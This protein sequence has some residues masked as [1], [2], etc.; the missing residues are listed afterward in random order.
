MRGGTIEL[1]RR[2]PM[3]AVRPTRSARAIGPQV[4]GDREA[5][6]FQEIG[7]QKA[8][9]AAPAKDRRLPED[10]TPWVIR[11]LG[12]VSGR[13]PARHARVGCAKIQ[14]PHFH[15]SL[16]EVAPCALRHLTKSHGRPQG[17]ARKCF[18]CYPGC[19]SAYQDSRHAHR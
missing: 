9:C 5:W 8:P 19:F 10:G 13:V 2:A 12:L 14:S 11:Q 6:I 17:F 15:I 4:P 18:L 7:R 16:N 3:K 1:Q